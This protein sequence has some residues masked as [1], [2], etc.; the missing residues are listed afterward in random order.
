MLHILV[1]GTVIKGFQRGAKLGYP[2]ANI[3]TNNLDI[4]NLD[5][6][7]YYGLSKLDIENNYQRMVM[8]IG[9]NPV[10]KNKERSLEVHVLKEYK[11]DFY[12]HNMNIK[13]IGFIRTMDIKFKDISELIDKIKSDIFIANLK[14]DEMD[15]KLQLMK[16]YDSLDINKYDVSDNQ[17]QL[18]SSLF[19]QLNDTDKLLFKEDYDNIYKLEKNKRFVL[20]ENMK[21]YIPVHTMFYTMILKR[22]STKEITMMLKKDNDNFNM[23]QHEAELIMKPPN[24]FNLWIKEHPIISNEEWE[25]GY[26]ESGLFENSQMYYLKFYNMMMLDFDNFELDELLDHLKKYD[27]FRF[28]IYKTH[29]GFHVFIINR[30]IPYNHPLSE[31]L[32]KEMLSDIYYN[33]FSNKTGFKVRLSSKLGRNEKKLYTY[34]KEIGVNYIHPTCYNLIQIHDKYIKIHK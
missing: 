11:D 31:Q 8:S 4:N 14:L 25:Y 23:T 28:R 22:F 17:R 24:K 18:I 32:G 21:K 12:D 5:D 26:Q 3:Q 16:E 9:Y 27:K 19:S 1:S 13:I 2:T 33:L 30:L 20:I 6:G 29:G 34:I 10:F 7:V 15:I